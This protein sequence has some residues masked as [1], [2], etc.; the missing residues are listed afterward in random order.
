MRTLSS[1]LVAGMD[2][3]IP[4]I[5]IGG[6]AIILLIAFF[7]GLRKGFSGIGRR[8]LSWGF[9]CAVFAVCE[10]F[11]HKPI[12]EALNMGA[13][14]DFATTT[15]FLAAALLL[16]FVVFAGLEKIFASV[17]KKQLARAEKIRVEEM[18]TGE[19]VTFDENKLHKHIHFDGK[20]KPSAINRF[21]GGVFEMVNVV[22]VVGLLVSLALLVLNF[23]P[24]RATLAVVYENET[25]AKIFGYLCTY[26]LDF[27]LIALLVVIVRYGYKSGIFTVVRTAG[28]FLLNIAVVVGSFYLPFSPL[29]AEGQPFHVITKVVNYLGGLILTAIPTD[30]PIA[31][32]QGVVYGAVKVGVGLVLCILLCITVKLMAWIFSKIQEA[33]DESDGACV[34][35]GVLG[36]LF[37]FVIGM[38]TVAVICCGLYLAQYYNTLNISAIFSDSAS[39]VNSFFGVF[40]QYLAPQ[41][42]TIGETIGL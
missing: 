12:A 18:A 39:L 15:V 16:R 14:G 4:Y 30:F 37:W 26:T 13:I 19:F 5:G 31:I 21:F 2:G 42:K 33:I 7:V 11:L 29:V 23:T 27:L 1:L 32:P 38:V 8:P 36:A 41:L 6:A 24:L 9:G 34:V 28:I 17:F 35:D 40:E 20:A 22:L 3:I 25:F 10:Y